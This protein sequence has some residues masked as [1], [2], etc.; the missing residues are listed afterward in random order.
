MTFKAKHEFIC[1]GCGTAEP[2]GTD[3]YYNDERD[4]DIFAT[5]HHHNP[6]P[7]HDLTRA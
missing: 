5:S 4:R 2:A 3:A 7:A 6:T 1:G